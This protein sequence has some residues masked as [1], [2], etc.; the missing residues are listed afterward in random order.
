MR[1]MPLHNIREPGLI[2]NGFQKE[3]ASPPAPD[4]RMQPEMRN[5]VE[6]QTDTRHAIEILNPRARLET[7]DINRTNNTDP[8]RIEMGQERQLDQAASRGINEKTP[9]LNDPYERLLRILLGEKPSAGQVDGRE[10][11]KPERTERAEK[12]LDTDGAGEPD[13]GIIEANHQA[14]NLSAL[15][16]D[17]RIPG[18]GDGSVEQGSPTYHQR[19]GVDAYRTMQAFAPGGSVLREA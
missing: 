16:T 1:V 10:A 6:A 8:P 2:P 13:R 4:P 9:A 14:E 19:R 7:N 17:R 15:I 12:P 11:D 5:R 18:H 3:E